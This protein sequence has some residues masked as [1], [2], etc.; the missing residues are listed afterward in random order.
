M[1]LFDGFKRKTQLDFSTNED[2]FATLMI[3]VANLDGEFD[4]EEVDTLIALAIINPAL[5]QVD[6][7]ACFNFGSKYVSQNGAAQSAVDVF[8]FLDSELHQTAFTYA[9]M[10]AMSDG[11]VTEEEENT[12]SE[13]AE[14]AELDGDADCLIHAAG[15][16]M[17]PVS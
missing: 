3:A 15:V 10:V 14:V 4:E 1:G 16:I 11:V 7:N 5:K 8:T 12:L 2:A 6:M 13:L 9:C 17:Q